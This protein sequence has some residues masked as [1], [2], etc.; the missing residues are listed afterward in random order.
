MKEQ[1]LGISDYKKIIENKYSY[2]DKTLL[3]QEL[4]F[5]AEVSVIPRPRRFGKTTNLSMLYYFFSNREEDNTHLFQEYKIW[6]PD[7]LDRLGRS[8]QSLMGQF[9]VIFMTLKGINQDNWED[10]YKKIASC[11]A[12]E[13]EKHR[14][15]LEAIS[16]DGKPLLSDTEKAKFLSILKETSSSGHNELSLQLLILWLHRYYDKRVIFLLDEYDAPIHAAY[17]HGY[18]DKMVVFMRSFLGDGLKDNP[19]LE[20]AVI[21]GVLR[22][23]R[24]SVFSGFNNATTYTILDGAFGDKFGF[25]EEEVES[26]LEEAGLSSKM[27]QV[28]EWYNGYD[29]GGLS[30]YNPWSILQ[31]LGNKTHILQPYWVNVSSNEI[32]KRLLWTGSRSL[33][34]DME[35]LLL[36]QSISKEI[37][38]GIVFADLKSQEDVVWSLFF[39]SGYLTLA[40][41]AEPSEPKELKIPNREVLELYKE[42]AKNWLKEYLDNTEDL[43]DM[44]QSLVTGNIPVFAKI[45]QMLVVNV[46]SFH[47]VPKDIS[48]SV[49]HAFVLG[50]LVALEK[51]HEVKSNRESGFGRYD[52][53]IIPKNVHELG[54]VIEFKK[55]DLEEK[56]DLETAVD[57]ALEQIREKQ[58]VAELHSRGVARVCTLGIAFQGK[59]ILVKKGTEI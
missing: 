1:A 28:R 33:K 41:K 45:F 39:F 40:G 18:Y 51:T 58:Y 10:A 25:L 55:V 2:I 15:L 47:D 52:V 38:E 29:I 7:C 37:K 36:G 50:L 54:I 19:L 5:N 23:A 56:E 6:N 30:I 4:S 12:I 3:I 21:T 16:S 35:R 14:F 27:P 20:K 13:F 48:E 49:Y 44:L 34:R 59:K 24:E 26:L 22:V 11:L 9:P 43:S 46:M 53:C 8:C 57:L 42:I 17:L 31:Y 32:I